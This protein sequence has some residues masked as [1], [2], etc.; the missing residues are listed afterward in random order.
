MCSIVGSEL[1][2][3]TF[4]KIVCSKFRSEQTFVKCY[5]LALKYFNQF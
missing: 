5:W 2:F 1:T 4:V 3:D